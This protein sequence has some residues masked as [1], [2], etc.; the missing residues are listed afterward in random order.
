MTS[1]EIAGRKF[2]LVRLS[3]P[4]KVAVSRCYHWLTATS[5]VFSAQNSSPDY[6]A[7]AGLSTSAFISYYSPHSPS[8]CVL[9]PNLCTLKINGVVYPF[10]MSL[11]CCLFR[12]LFLS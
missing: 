3:I 11:I 9:C 6:F 8:F 4:T 10:L 5:F 1:T 2:P 7:A 12:A